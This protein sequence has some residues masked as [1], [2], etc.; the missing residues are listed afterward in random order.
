MR[1]ADRATRGGESPIGTQLERAETLGAVR[2]VRSTVSPPSH[3]QRC[4]FGTLPQRRRRGAV[5]K[6]SEKQH[7]ETDV[8]ERLVVRKNL[9]AEVRIQIGKIAR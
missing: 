7:R 2:R 9:C 1:G 6:F 4:Y 5:V 3:L 8:L